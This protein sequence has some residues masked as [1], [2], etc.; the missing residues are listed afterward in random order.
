MLGVVGLT[1]ALKLQLQ[2]N[3]QVIIIAEVLPSDPK[4]IR[5]ASQWAVRG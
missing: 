4:T 5:Y 1:T 3:Y 2:E